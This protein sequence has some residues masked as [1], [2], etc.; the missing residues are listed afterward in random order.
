MNQ[1]TVVSLG[2]RMKSALLAVAVG[3]NS[4]AAIAQTMPLGRFEARGITMYLAPDGA[5]TWTNARGLLVAGSFRIQGERIAF[6]DDSGSVACRAGPGEYVFDIS[7]DTL[8]FQVI[9]DPCDGRRGALTSLWLRSRAALAL[10]HATLIDGTGSPPRPGMTVVMRGGVIL[11]IH[12]DGAVR[13]P[14]DA[15]VRD[16]SGHWVIPGLIDGHVHV[17][18]SPSTQDSRERVERRLHNALRGGVVAVRDMAGDARALADLS[19]AAAAGDI[20]VPTIRYAAVFAGPAFFTDP[21]VR[22][23][24]VGVPIGTAPWAR[25][26]TDTTDLRQA[27]AEARGAGA[28][29]VKLY[30]ELNGAL[31]AKIAAEAKRQ[32]VRVWAHFALFPAR[33]SDV[34]RAG[35]DVV[36]HAPLIAWEIGDSMPG[37]DQRGRYDVSV[38]P[39]DPAIR[40]VITLMRERSVILEPTLFVFRTVGPAAD[41]TI[42]R[43]REQLAA[44]MTRA[45]Y[46]AGVR[47]SAGTDGIGTEDEGSLPN[48][49]EELRL[50][51]DQAGLT[52]MDALIAATRHA[53]EAAGLLQT[54][55]TVA[56]GKAADLVVLRGDPT[57]DIRNTRL[58]AYVLKKGQVVK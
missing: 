10:V 5:S 23:S 16:A 22:A 25:A 21:R 9:S 53:A 11:A 35:A 29:A 27:V 6:S 50:L 31:A 40:R 51:V 42:A 46:Q 41:T 44:A 54:H 57:V 48:I 30:G 12:P 26:I 55:G 1:P 47:I 52:P 14:D 24:S 2:I 43:R 4:P 49:H 7:G 15:N 20:D 32:R 13:I 17:A 33:P 45:A 19:R 18:T 56:V 58:I 28:T 34:V 8:R 37:A 38:T 39:D 36:S 3:A